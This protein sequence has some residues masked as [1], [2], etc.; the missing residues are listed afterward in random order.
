MELTL[1]V[2]NPA[3][4]AVIGR[5]KRSGNR[6]FEWTSFETNQPVVG[7]LAVPLGGS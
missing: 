5:V 2:R 7:Q 3:R 6:D 4:Y 1:L